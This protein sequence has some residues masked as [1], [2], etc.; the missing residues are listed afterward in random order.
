VLH[1]D[2]YFEARMEAL[3]HEGLATR[4]GGDTVLIVEW[5]DRLA[6]WWPPDRLEI[7]LGPADAPERRRLGLQALGPRSEE[8]LAAFLGSLPAG[9][10]PEMPEPA[11]RGAR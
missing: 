10:M 3:L 1:L 7:R 2:A 5:A 11:P 9:M 6:S 8:I 4:F